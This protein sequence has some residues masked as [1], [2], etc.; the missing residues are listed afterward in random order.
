MPRAK[1]WDGESVSST[2]RLRHTLGREGLSVIREGRRQGRPFF[3]VTEYVWTKG[4]T[5][6]VELGSFRASG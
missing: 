4:A 3:I 1:V 5:P 6:S 2:V